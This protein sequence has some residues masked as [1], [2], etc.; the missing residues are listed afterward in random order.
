MLFLNLKVHGLGA[1]TT[2]IHRDVTEDGF[3]VENACDG[4][5]LD[6][7]SPWLT[8]SH[9]KKAFNRSRGGNFVSF[10]PCIEQVSIFFEKILVK[11]FHRKLLVKEKALEK[12]LHLV[13]IYQ[14]SLNLS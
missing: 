3:F 13:L 1:V 7:P 14:I 5:F 6:I 8:V 11:I 12:N 9:A 10:S 4:V 2:C